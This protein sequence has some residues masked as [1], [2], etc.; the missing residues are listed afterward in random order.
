MP[1]G[2]PAAGQRGGRAVERQVDRTFE[3]RGSGGE[4]ALSQIPGTVVY[5]KTG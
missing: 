5:C 3:W 1:D 4:T 2:M